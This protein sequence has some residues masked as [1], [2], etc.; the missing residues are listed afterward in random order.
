M[1][2]SNNLESE[3]PSVL[4]DSKWSTNVAFRINGLHIQKEDVNEE[5]INYMFAM[6][7]IQY[8]RQ[9]SIPICKNAC[10]ISPSVI[11]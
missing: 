11:G 7:L 1:I 2:S 8:S 9:R 4:L 10:F 6:S 3:C 5:V